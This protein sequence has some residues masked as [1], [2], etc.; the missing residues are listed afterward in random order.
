VVERMRVG[1][2][3]C[4]DISGIYIDNA[5]RLGAYEIAAVCDLD[6]AKATTAAEKAGC[7]T[8]AFDAMLGDRTIETVLNITPPA[9]HA[10]VSEAALNAGKH[11]YTEKPIAVELGRAKGLIELAK[12]RGLLIS[13]APDT[14][15]GAGYA[16]AR[17]LVR[18][19]A[20]GRVTSG[21]GFML[22]AGPE[23]WH[24][25]P[26]FF[27]APGG[28]PLLDM[29]PYY[30][31]ALVSMLGP[32]GAV[33]AT[34]GMGNET[35]TI[36]SGLKKGQPIDVATPTHVSAT[37]E[38]AGGALVT[39]VM[40][41]DVPAHTLPNI[42]LYGTGG[43]LTLP[44]PNT[45]GGEIK[46]CKGGDEEWRTVPLD[47]GHDENARGLGLVE[48]AAAIRGDDHRIATGDTA[49]HVLEAMVGALRSGETGRRVPLGG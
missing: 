20:I 10:A 16:T 6:A 47:D 19:G 31:S 39:L 5:E 25:D 12:E 29:G 33:T 3:G 17:R 8:V 24:P 18:E 36:G 22:T 45:F 14:I 11:V 37:Y 13:C 26:G 1:I 4:G 38:F 7:E 46:L 40:S 44:D 42:Q 49:V 2:V 28:G 32:V 35:R 48:L 43:A 34:T 27:F 41:F 30:L 9:A 23:S 21:T 15:L